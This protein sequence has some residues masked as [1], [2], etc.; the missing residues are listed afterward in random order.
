MAS[1]VRCRVADLPRQWR[2]GVGRLANPTGV[3]ILPIHLDWSP[4]GREWD[5]SVAAHRRRVS[6][7]VLEN[8]TERDVV[9]W[10]DPAQ[11]R[12][13]FDDMVLPRSVLEVWQPWFDAA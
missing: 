5:L 13:D 8:G 6:E 1:T 9:E 3:V 12:A 7:L 10:L 11:L 2:D 4:P